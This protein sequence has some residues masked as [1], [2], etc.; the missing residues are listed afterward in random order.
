MAEARGGTFSSNGNLILINIDQGILII[1]R[2]ADGGLV[3]SI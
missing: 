3:N 1:I 2:T